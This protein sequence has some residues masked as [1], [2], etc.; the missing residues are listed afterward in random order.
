MTHLLVTPWQHRAMG[1]LLDKLERQ[2]RAFMHKSQMI[3]YDEFPVEDPAQRDPPR[4]RHHDHL[5]KRHIRSV[6]RK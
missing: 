1:E 2:P 5:I 3:A 6:Q 4:P